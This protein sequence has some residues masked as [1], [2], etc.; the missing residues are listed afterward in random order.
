VHAGAGN[1]FVNGGGGTD[2][3]DGGLGDDVVEG[4]SGNDKLY[5]LAGR[6]MLS[7]RGGNDDLFDGA[8]SALVI[9]GRG[10]DRVTLGGGR[11]V[12]AFNRGDERDVV[13]GTGQAAL[14][15][16]GGIRYQD[17][18][19]RRSGDDLIVEVGNGERIT[20][21]EWY[22]D[23]QHQMVQTM[24]V[25]AEAMQGY[26]QASANPLLDDK[27]EWFDFGALVA[28]FDDARQENR[29]IARWSMM[30]A[31]LDAHLGGS[32]GAALGGDLAYQ[33]GK[34]GSLAGVGLAAA[35]SVLEATGFGAEAQALT[36]PGTAADGTPKLG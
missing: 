10:N 23:P 31:L 34:A 25:V 7:G 12:V 35:Q 26:A 28:A 9:G 13:R 15:L 17:L 20:L 36:P 29:N 8:G 16:G 11:D 14:S 32:D 24:Q 3:L 1:D 6:N 22:A 4:D 2:V 33:Y 21:G 5:D 19:L 27:V 18:A 30:N